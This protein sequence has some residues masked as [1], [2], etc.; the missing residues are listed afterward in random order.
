M[1]QEKSCRA[2]L[3]EEQMSIAMNRFQ[4]K[5]KPFPPI[6]MMS[7]Q[8]LFNRNDVIKKM[9]LF[10]RCNSVFLRREFYNAVSCNIK[11]WCVMSPKAPSLPTFL[12]ANT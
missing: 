5:I 1:Y 4:Q 2:V 6:R 7:W 3:P 8:Q 10:L 9:K 12:I 11:G